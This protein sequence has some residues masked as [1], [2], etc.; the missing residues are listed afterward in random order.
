MRKI[1]LIGLV[2]VLVLGLSV[3]VGAI[4]ASGA[5]DQEFYSAL[6]FETLY[7][8]G[9]NDITYS[10]P[11]PFNSGIP[12]GLENFSYGGGWVYGEQSTTW[13]NFFPVFSGYFMSPILSPSYGT[14]QSFS[15]VGG[16][17]I[18][19]VSRLSEYRIFWD[20]SISVDSF[21]VTGSFWVVDPSIHDSGRYGAKLDQFQ[22]SGYPTNGEILLG[23]LLIQC[24]DQETNYDSNVFLNDI[25]LEV[26]FTRTD[27]DTARF[28]FVVPT[29]GLNYPNGSS[30][31]NNWLYEQNVRIQVVAPSSSDFDLGSWL[32]ETLQGFLQVEIFPGFS[33][34]KIFYLVLVMGVLL[35]FI[36]MII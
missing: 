19:R 16:Q 21:K 35:W 1:I 29:S 34:D 30:D 5:S 33:I 27:V 24:F 28:D 6:S 20:S 36:T 25:K 7:F 13:D 18:V 32:G 9:S 23:E 15:L 4:G 8:D 26:S 11:F 17:Q 12:G 31:F 22:I 14:Y 10:V 3:S 2:V